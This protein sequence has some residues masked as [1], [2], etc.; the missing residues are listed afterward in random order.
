MS[1]NNDNIYQKFMEKYQLSGT[2]S[3]KVLGIKPSKFSEFKSGARESRT[4]ILHH[5]DTFFALNDEIAQEIIK[6]RLK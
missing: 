4:Y 6:Q 5:I 1:D 3:A 2:E